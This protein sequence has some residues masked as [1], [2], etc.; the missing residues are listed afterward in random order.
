MPAFTMDEATVDFN[1]EVKESSVSAD[2]S[3]ESISN[4][5]HLETARKLALG[6]IRTV[7]YGENF[8]RQYLY[9][10]CCAC[11]NT[12]GKKLW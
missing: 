6:P 11:S 9:P 1:M 10:H 4:T 2:T 7:N 5:N 8:E 3:S 12:Q